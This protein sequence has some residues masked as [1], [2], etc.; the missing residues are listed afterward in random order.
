MLLTGKVKELFL[1]YKDRLLRFGSEIIFMICKTLGIK[2]TILYEEESITPEQQMMKDF[3]AFMTV[4][5]AKMHGQ[6]SH[7]NR[8]ALKEVLIAQ[9]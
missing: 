7:K 5:A 9:V 2:V 3:L 8:K 4:Y 6:R 1:T